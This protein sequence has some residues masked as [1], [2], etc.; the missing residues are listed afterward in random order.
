MRR[1]SSLKA[2][3]KHFLLALF[4]RAVKSHKDE[5]VKSRSLSQLRRH[6]SLYQHF[7]KMFSNVSELSKS[8]VLGYRSAADQRPPVEYLRQPIASPFIMACRSGQRLYLV[9]KGGLRV[10]ASLLVSMLGAFLRLLRIS[11]IDTETNRAVTMEDELGALLSFAGKSVEGLEQLVHRLRY[12][13]EI[14]QLVRWDEWPWDYVYQPLKRSVIQLALDNQKRVLKVAFGNEVPQ[15][16][17]LSSF[18]DHLLKRIRL[19]SDKM[20]YF[21]LGDA[22]TIAEELEEKMTQTWALLRENNDLDYF[23]SLSNDTDGD[24]GATAGSSPMSSDSGVAAPTASAPTSPNPPSTRAPPRS[25]I[26]GPHP[27]SFCIVCSQPTVM[28][29]NSC[30]STYYCSTDCQRAHWPTHYPYCT[31]AVGGS[32]LAPSTTQSCKALVLF[33]HTSTPH[34][35]MID[36]RIAAPPASG[37]P[38]VIE[39]GLPIE[40]NLGNSPASVFCIK[41]VGG[42]SLSRPYQVFFRNSF[43]KDGS[44]INLAVKSLHPEIT[45]PWAGNM[46]VFKFDGSRREKYEHMEPSDLVQIAQFFRTYPNA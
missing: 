43:L 25:S 7:A 13:A 41:G 29:C 24:S 33:A 4:F 22:N 34:W 27:V 28:S 19:H 32:A 18:Q 31:I 3:C 38:R 37:A 1:L 20:Q 44:P 21:R 26:N 8:R 2:Q 11:S 5:F 46:V 15:N 23:P 17:S 39:P 42:S 36:V 40:L 6:M 16:I 35:K 9:M 14:P 10:L 12:L 45:Y 30:H